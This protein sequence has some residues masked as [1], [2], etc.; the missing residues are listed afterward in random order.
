[1]VVDLIRR[2]YKTGLKIEEGLETWQ[3]TIVLPAIIPALR[4]FILMQ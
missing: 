2:T 4:K 3:Q 1:M